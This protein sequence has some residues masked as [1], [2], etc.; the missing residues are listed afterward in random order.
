MLRKLLTLGVLA[1]TAAS[2]PIL[3]QTN[4]QA[5]ENGLVRLFGGEPAPT[6]QPA[7]QTL[8]FK[9]EA[10]PAT[11]S[12][13]KVRIEAD[14]RGHFQG[15]FRLNG[16]TVEALV[17][18]GATLVAINRSTARRIGI[19]LA[20]GDFRYEVGT[21][22]GKVAA[23]AAIIDRLQIGRIDVTGVQAVILDDR[24]LEGTLIGM[25]FLNRLASY[26]VENGSLVLEQ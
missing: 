2:V 1:G 20:P 10:R 25:S 17:D 12:G 4:P 11:L 24:A 13:R 26:S 6:P 8:Q 5:F 7:A 18:T 21:A 22:N 16:R 9:A 19:E 14:A 15:D 23:A 3:Y